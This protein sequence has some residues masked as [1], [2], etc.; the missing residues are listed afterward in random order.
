MLLHVVLAPALAV[1]DFDLLGPALGAAVGCALLSLVTST[2]RLLLSVIVALLALAARVVVALRAGLSGFLHPLGS[3]LALLVHPA[4]GLLVGVVDAVCHTLARL[5]GALGAL[6][7][8]L[9]GALLAAVAQR[10]RLVG[11]EELALLAELHHALRERPLDVVEV[12]GAL[13]R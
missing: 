2:S 12:D 8:G 4:S 7:H 13:T 11:D 3:A 6:L 9:V 10:E 5:V 1:L